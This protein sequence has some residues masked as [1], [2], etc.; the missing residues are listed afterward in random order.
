MC[1][2]LCALFRLPCKTPQYCCIVRFPMDSMMVKE[3]FCWCL[4]L[5]HHTKSSLHPQIL[6]WNLK[7]MVSKRTFLF[8]GLIFRFHVKFRGCIW[9]LPKQCF[10]REKNTLKIGALIKSHQDRVI[11]WPPYKDLDESVM[12]QDRKKYIHQ[13]NNSHFALENT[14]NKSNHLSRFVLLMEEILQHLGCTKPCK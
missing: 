2:F 6:T 12:L 3:G 14:W 5:K 9:N 11:W 1:L 4:L 7:I 10:L 13:P 8:Q